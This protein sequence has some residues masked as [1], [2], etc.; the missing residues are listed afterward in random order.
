MDINAESLWNT[1]GQWGCTL[2]STT[3]SQ[4]W[5]GHI[6]NVT[7]V[8]SVALRISNRN[9]SFISLNETEM[10]YIFDKVD[11]MYMT[12]NI[13]LYACMKS[14]GCSNSYGHNIESSWQPVVTM[15]DARISYNELFV[16]PNVEDPSVI[17]MEYTLLGNTF[18]NQESLPT[19]GN[20]RSY[21]VIVEYF[22]DID[23]IQVNKLHDRSIDIMYQF[24]LI[25]RSTSYNGNVFRGAL[26]AITLG[27]MCWYVTSLYQHNPMV[28]S[29]L[30]ERKWIVLYF[31]ALIL[32][33]N[34]VYCVIC[35]WDHVSVEWI[36]ASY[37]LDNLAQ[38]AFFYVWLLFSDSLS[39]KFKYVLFYFPKVTMAA[40]LFLSE[41]VVIVMQFPSV[42]PT[43]DRSASLA[44]YNWSKNT[45]I[46]FIAF[47]IGYF[48]L[49]CVW[50]IWWLINLSST[51]NHLSKL[52]YMNTRYLQLSFR[53]FYLQ[54]ILLWMYY[55]LEYVVVGYIIF[56]NSP[57]IWHQNI[58][59][60]T[61]SINT[62]FRHQT[63]LDGKVVFLTVYSIIL[64]YLFL[65]PSYSSYYHI[66]EN[67]NDSTGYEGRTTQELLATT[68]T[69]TENEMSAIVKKKKKALSESRHMS[70]ALSSLYDNKIE[71]FCLDVAL[72]LLEA[73]YEAY[74]DTLI[75][76]N[77]GYGEADWKKHGYVFVDH[78]YDV[79]LETYC[80]ITRHVATNKL[81]VAFR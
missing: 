80:M 51:A 13:A 46:L 70:T 47:S 76:T 5:V 62:L 10:G 75:K 45:K 3:N 81:V 35:W 16:Q 17:H 74:Y 78:M 20:I 43:T 73:A 72:L 39:R 38:A 12:Y 54:S 48:V 30:H 37:A 23:I 7:N 77:S 27:I 34:P 69:V 59:N 65:P 19:K 21:L 44:V 9:E 40:L 41:M 71:V 25:S 6:G 36:F 63:L 52:S 14:T 67:S 56:H 11:D 58:D 49:V 2:E 29:W 22:N 64:G 18:Q 24:L 28:T 60:L 79:Q 8:I 42:N 31:I 57:P 50:M 33:Q 55:I 15:S 1:D 61:D 66:G 68:Y 4:I 32:Y 26:L 53:F